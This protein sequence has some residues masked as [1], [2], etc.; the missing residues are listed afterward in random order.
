MVGGAD[1][2]MNSQESIEVAI[3]DGQRQKEV[4]SVSYMLLFNILLCCFL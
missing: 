3:S 4:E 1:G 2:L